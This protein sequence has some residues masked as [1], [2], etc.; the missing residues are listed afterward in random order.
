M[1]VYYAGIL[2]WCTAGYVAVNSHTLAFVFL[3]LFCRQSQQ[4]WDIESCLV[5]RRSLAAALGSEIEEYVGRCFI[6]S[7]GND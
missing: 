2:C 3:V 4:D 1:L 6:G 7:S 5:A